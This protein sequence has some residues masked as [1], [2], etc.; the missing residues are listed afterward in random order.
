MSNPTI[1]IRNLNYIQ[2]A[3]VGELKPHLVAEA[4]QDISKAYGNLAATQAATQA[5]LDAALARIAALEK[6]S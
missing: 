3:K 1:S 4:L 6:G 5:S 2:N